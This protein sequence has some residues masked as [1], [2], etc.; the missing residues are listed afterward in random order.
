MIV[1]SEVSVVFV[2]WFVCFLSFQC[3]ELS[4]LNDE[5]TQPST[6]LFWISFFSGCCFHMGPA[7]NVS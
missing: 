5:I 7:N 1:S 3:A 4:N 6:A 2:G